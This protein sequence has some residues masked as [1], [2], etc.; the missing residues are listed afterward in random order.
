MRDQEGRVREQEKDKWKER[1]LYVCRKSDSLVI[2][3][4][5]A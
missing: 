2:L 5:V 3:S 4:F 1:D